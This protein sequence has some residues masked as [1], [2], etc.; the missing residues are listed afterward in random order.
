MKRILKFTFFSLILVLA[1]VLLVLPTSAAGEKVVYVS[2]AGRGDGSTPE[3]PIGNAGGYTV[4]NGMDKSNAFYRALDKLKDTGGTIVVV[5]ELSIDVAETRVPKNKTEKYA[6]CEFRCPTIAKGKTITLT[7]V[8][9][10]V[11]YR[12]KGAKLILDHDKCNT[13]LFIFGCEAL[14]E[15]ID[16]EYKYD[17]VSMNSYEAP[18]MFGGGAYK[19]TVGEGINV[20][21]FDVALNGEG[22]LYPVLLGGYRYNK[23]SRSTDITV[24]SGKWSTVIAGSFG[25]SEDYG[26]IGGDANLTVTG[27]QIGIVIGTGSFDRPT[28]QV[29][30]HTRMNIVGGEIEY[31]YACNQK[32]YNGKSITVNVSENA[33]LRGFEYAPLDY[34]GD[35]E[36][37]KAKVSVINK[38]KPFDEPIPEQQQSENPLHQETVPIKEKEDIY[39]KLTYGFLYFILLLAVLIP[40]G[41]VVIYFTK[42]LV[43]KYKK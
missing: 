20:T 9:G 3:K 22:E 39:D 31:I 28:A 26:R 33:K 23:T 32:E 37:L 40:I 34:N 5:G 13:S 38:A 6:P 2:S 41:Y 36:K 10:G 1:S 12:E 27:G 15:N 43:L 42:L 29:E 16:I 4:D 21:S 17:S 35:I 18:F 7:S 19:F 25:N 11:D 30:G 8:Y 14:I 24:K